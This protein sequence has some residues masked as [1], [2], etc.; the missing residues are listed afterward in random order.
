VPA[1][2]SAALWLVPVSL[3]AM[4]P[5]V[6]LRTARLIRARRSAILLYHG[7]GATST[8]IDPG[9]LRVRPEAFRAQLGLLLAA[10]FE[11]VTVGEFAE[12]SGGR[13]PRPGMVALSFDDGMDDNHSVV[14]PILRKHGLRATVYVT[15][16]LIG[17][18]NPWMARESGARMMTV[19][20]LHDLVAAGFEIGAHTVSHPDL[21]RL[22][23]DDCLRE[24]RESRDELK[25]TL[26]VE[27][28]TFAY[29]SCRYG[30][31]AVEAARAAGFT[32]AVTCQGLGSWKR[33]EL[34]RSLV[35]GKD[36]TASFLVKLT[37][38]YEPLAASPPGR[39]ARA[40]TRASRDR[41]R[42]RREAGG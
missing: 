39:L 22:G 29:P 21:S 2:C 12:R 1:R 37:G 38:L 26:G 28:R 20:E 10:G 24:M 16:G 18:P 40:R 42:E 8:R 11:I 15:T 5:Q 30:L 17:K 36:G 7:V 14:L 3:A 13:R 32:A 6:A 41:R 35:S 25:R 34:R 31:A 27:V 4:T 9:F 19:D 33:Y 23:F